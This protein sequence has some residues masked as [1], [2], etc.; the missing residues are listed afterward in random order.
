M[1]ILVRIWCIYLHWDCRLWRW[2]W[3]R[4]SRW[5]SP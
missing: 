2:F 3:C 5:S 4:S 1:T